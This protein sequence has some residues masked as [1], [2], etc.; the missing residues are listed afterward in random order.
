MCES[1]ISRKPTIFEIN[2]HF[3]YFFKH[4]IHR[5]IITI[6][7]N[8]FP[9]FRFIMNRLLGFL[10]Q[11]FCFLWSSNNTSVFLLSFK[12]FSGFYLLFFIRLNVFSIFSAVYLHTKEWSLFNGLGQFIH[13]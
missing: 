8:L 11:I 7:K 1:N 5:F 3:F 2:D 13:R 9:H 4:S 6:I 12:S 10:R